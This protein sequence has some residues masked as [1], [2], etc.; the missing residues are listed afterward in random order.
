MKN[1][2]I[3][4]LF[5]VPTGSYHDMALR[6][7]NLHVSGDSLDRLSAATDGFRNL[8]TGS[9]AG[10]AGSILRPMTQ[11]VGTL[12]I[13]NGW[14]E[15]RYM[16]MMEVVH[17]NNGA[18]DFED[19]STRVQY[20]SGYTDFSGDASYTGRIDPGM[21]MYLNTVINTR[22]FRGQHRR[23]ISANRYL[24]QNAGQHGQY[25]EQYF[26]MR[27]RDVCQTVGN[28]GLGDHVAVDF[29]TTLSSRPLM[30]NV[31]NDLPTDYMARTFQSYQ[32]AMHTA[33]V[34]DDIPTLMSNVASSTGDEAALDD[35]FI[36][37]LHRN[38]ELAEGSC[39]AYGELCTL[40]PG[41]DDVAHIVPPTEMLTRDI[42]FAQHTPANSSNWVGSNSETVV[43]TIVGSSV[44][45]LMTDAM[46]TQVSF[47]ISND[48]VNGQPTMEWLS[49]P[50]SF[51]MVGEDLENQATYFTNRMLQEI[52]RDLTN[53]GNM[54]LSLSLFSDL[55]MADTRLEVQIDGGDVV[56]FCV[57]NFASSMITP[58]IANNRMQLDDMASGVNQIFD[59]M[60]PSSLQYP[61]DDDFTGGFNLGGESLS[62]AL[63]SRAAP[64]S[65]STPRTGSWKV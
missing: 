36:M 11:S 42:G 65:A 21:R 52:F 63:N 62:S 28:S 9:F 1:A 37:N 16:F 39:F 3:T 12:S 60:A 5:F 61:S 54:T 59:A 20:I 38:T 45:A 31:R 56:P 17:Y 51:M 14:N 8:S 35:P 43:S 40:F 22:E 7:Y 19:S 23:G 50:Q 34:Q 58:V 29:R 27:P 64:T 32:L 57:P 18:S 6:P 15:Q 41:T 48:T 47:Y 33:D 10:V 46:L 4:K 2:K 30:S 24:Q 53:N 13:P 25:G 49:Q 44:P 55:V 26:A